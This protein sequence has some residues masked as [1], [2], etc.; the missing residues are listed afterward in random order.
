MINGR[1]FMAH[2]TSLKSI[3]RELSINPKMKCK[4]HLFLQMKRKKC[5]LENN[6]VNKLIGLDWSTHEQHTK[7]DIT[8]TKNQ[9]KKTLSVCVCVTLKANT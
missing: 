7:W 6:A 5:A 9:K 4:S 1:D 3:M 2:L 8:E